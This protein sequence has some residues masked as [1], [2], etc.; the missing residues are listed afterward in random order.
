MDFNT[1]RLGNRGVP[2]KQ[3][4]ILQAY[5]LQ[6]SLTGINGKVTMEI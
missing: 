3:A 5:S 2:L 4:C 1:T 6:G